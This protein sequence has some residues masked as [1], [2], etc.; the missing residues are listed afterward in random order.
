MVRLVQLRRNSTQGF[1][2]KETWVSGFNIISVEED[3]NM[4]EFF[5][6]NKDQFPEGLSANT[7]FSK[8]RL[9]GVGAATDYLQVIGTPESIADKL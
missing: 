9:L 4:A 7:V 6:D 2:L 1:S 3:E 8:I 5:R